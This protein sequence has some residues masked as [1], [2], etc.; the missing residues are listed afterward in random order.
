MNKNWNFKRLHRD[1][2][3]DHDAV[4]AHN[5]EALPV[6]V[7]VDGHPRH[8]DD[9]IQNQQDDAA[10]SDVACQFAAKVPPSNSVKRIKHLRDS[11][12]D[13][14]S[15]YFLHVHGAKRCSP[16][17]SHGVHDLQFALQLIEIC[18]VAN[19]RSHHRKQGLLQLSRLAMWLFKF[20][21]ERRRH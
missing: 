18:D 9:A 16:E 15:E 2:D 6:F 3:G 11:I 20:A 8:R 21:L 19:C 4:R 12:F 1:D 5:I 10:P 7:L 14:R 13:Q 17:C